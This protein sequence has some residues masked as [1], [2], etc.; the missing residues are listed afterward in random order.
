MKQKV[1]VGAR[2]ALLLPFNNLGLII[3]DEEHD[4]SYKQHDP[5]PRYQARDLAGLFGS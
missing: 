3:V 5:A 4:P 1:I 2:S